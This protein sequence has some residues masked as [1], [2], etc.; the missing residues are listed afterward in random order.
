MH[1]N[2][3][4]DR[5]RHRPRVSAEV[6]HRLVTAAQE[7]DAHAR[8]QLVDEFMPLIA[9]VARLYRSTPG[10]EREELLQEGVVG[11]LRAVER[12]DPTLG[13]PFWAYA[14]WWVRQAM[15]QLV[16]ELTRPVVLSDRAARQLARVRDAQRQALVESGSEPSRKQLAA[17]TGLPVEQVDRLLAVD[18]TPRST[19]EAATTEDGAAGTLCDLLADPL[20][21][22]EYDGVLA[23][24]ET[25]T[26]VAGMAGLT[27]R[28]RM[29]L[30]ARHGFD[31]EEQNLRQ[32]ADRLGI[33]AERVRQV[34][35]RALR[36]L[37][38]ACHPHDELSAVGDEAA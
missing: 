28:E 7:G 14:S 35:Q 29:I 25:K 38:A 17:R 3:N 26:V 23:A 6:A 2:R 4:I 34:E 15:Q 16:S 8:A 24:F 11:L 37:A 21:E 19:E 10:V 18:R 36:K 30:R 33:S 5:Q 1:T 22:S 13:T 32:L 20:A 9:S 31:G 12:F 27:K